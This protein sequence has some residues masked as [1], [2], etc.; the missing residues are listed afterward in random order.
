MANSS[1]INRD[2]EV[3]L[4]INIRSRSGPE[5]SERAIRELERHGV[6]VRESHLVGSSRA[7]IGSV[8]GAIARG[9]R[10][11]VIGGGDGT[12]STAVDLLATKPE[13]TMG[14]LP[15]GTGNEAAR[16]LGIP[17][18]LPGAC[19]VI[20]RGRV[21]TVDLAET[22]GNYFIHTAMI[23]Y[24]AEVNCRVPSWLKQRFG[25]TAYAY[26]FLRSIVGARP[27]RVTMAVGEARW[28]GETILVIVGNGR[29]H[30]PASVLL[31]RPEAAESGLLVYTPR[32]TNWTSLAKLAIDLWVARRPRP[33][34]LLFRR[35]DKVDIAADPPQV[36][37]LDGE[38]AH[39]TPLTIQ[40]A[41]NALRV[42]AP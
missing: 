41:R 17:L 20:S 42:L 28:E 7:L 33:S 35:V 26:T 27:F 16:V 37:D 8:Q 32:S 38:F 6:R 14:L 22:G 30:A 13:L 12:I 3:A 1:A 4:V 29:F 9:C 18:D 40:I 21:H 5:A 25:K 15:M 10:T 36:V 34:L 39:T 31:P 24:P 19:E 2:N 23:G 11:I